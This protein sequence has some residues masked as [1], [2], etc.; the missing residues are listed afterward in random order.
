MAVHESGDWE[1]RAIGPLSRVRGGHLKAEGCPG[2]SRHQL[3]HHLGAHDG[4]NTVMCKLSM[5]TCCPMKCRHIGRKIY[6]NINKRCF[7]YVMPAPWKLNL[8]RPCCSVSDGNLYVVFLILWYFYFITILLYA[9]G[10][11]CVCDPHR[12]QI[13]VINMV[14]EYTSKHKGPFGDISCR[15]KT[16]FQKCS[17][18]IHLFQQHPQYVCKWSFHS[19][20]NTIR[21]DSVMTPTLF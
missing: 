9:R 3:V 17:S 20:V 2:F 5:I 16:I 6:D 12:L 19:E 7:I 11:Q 13:V 21:E 4:L 8:Q 14:P 1:R 15:L 10:F 18:L